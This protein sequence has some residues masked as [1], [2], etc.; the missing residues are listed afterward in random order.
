MNTLRAGVIVRWNGRVYNI[1]EYVS[2]GLYQ[3]NDIKTYQLVH[4][5]REEM[6][7]MSKARQA[8]TRGSEKTSGKPW[9][10]SFYAWPFEVGEFSVYDLYFDYG[11]YVLD[12]DCFDDVLRK[13]F[14][15]EKSRGNVLSVE[16]FSAGLIENPIE[17]WIVGEEVH[18]V[19]MDK[20]TSGRESEEDC[21][22]VV[23]ERR[24]L[25]GCPLRVL[26]KV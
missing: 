17:F 14:E 5:P 11:F 22:A 15:N 24:R 23:R 18:R 20:N 1:K 6:K 13:Y 8:L 16:D 21:C 19:V 26:R 7:I 4:I 9:K 3:A 25:L 10:N 2:H 12:T